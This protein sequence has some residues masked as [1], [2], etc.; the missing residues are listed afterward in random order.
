[1]FWDLTKHDTEEQRQEKLW[2]AGKATKEENE[3]KAILGQQGAAGWNKVITELW[4]EHVNSVPD[5]EIANSVIAN[6]QI[7]AAGVQKAQKQMKYPSK[8]K[9]DGELSKGVWM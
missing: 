5:T 3:I 4:M 2:S 1:M 8:E 7:Q 6:A 9:G